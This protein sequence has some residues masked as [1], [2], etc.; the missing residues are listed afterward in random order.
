M[1]SYYREQTPRRS[2]RWRERPKRYDFAAARAKL[3]LLDLVAAHSPGGKGSLW[4]CP[5]HGRAPS[6]G[7]TPSLSIYAE[8]TRWKCHSCD[9]GGD[10]ITFRSMIESRSISEVMGELEGAPVVA[11]RVVAATPRPTAAPALADVSAAWTR[12]LA[13]A[14]VAPADHRGRKYIDDRFGK[15]GCF[16]ALTDEEVIGVMGPDDPEAWVRTKAARGYLVVLPM[17]GAPA[18]GELSTSAPVALNARAVNDAKPKYMR[19]A[20]LAGAICYGS[21]PKQV[22]NADGHTLAVFEGVGDYL[23]ALATAEVSALAAG[24]LAYCSTG[25]ASKFGQAL[26][27]Q[28]EHARAL[29]RRGPRRVVVF[30]HDDENGAGQDAART[31]LDTLSSM[32]GVELLARFGRRAA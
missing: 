30:A 13:R 28:V 14:R 24:V 15:I 19:P 4:A 29:G 10:A 3:N 26:K 11:A 8:G 5:W 32:P 27:R 7:G 21:I 23:R 31:V 22:M 20:G 1:S 17:Y 12:A 25:T 6:A 18:S 2:A 16:D 9:R